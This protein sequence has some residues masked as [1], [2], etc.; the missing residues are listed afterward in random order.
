MKT[1]DRISSAD[2]ELIL[3]H[4]EASDGSICIGFEDSQWHTHPDLLSH[5]LNVNESEA[6][7]QFKRLLLEDQLPI[8]ISTDGGRTL[9]PWVSDNLEETMRLYGAQN[10]ILRTWNRSDKWHAL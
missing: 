6:I 4:T 7:T 1:I 10:C 2:G 5:W 3:L 9:E 8:I